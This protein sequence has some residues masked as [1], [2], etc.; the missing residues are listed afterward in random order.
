MILGYA[1]CVGGLIGAAYAR[2]AAQLI[3]TQGVMYAVG[4][5]TLILEY[6][7]GSA[8]LTLIFDRPSILPDDELHV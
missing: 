1:I 6:L 3:V 4:G 2:T 8:I 7:S 5:S